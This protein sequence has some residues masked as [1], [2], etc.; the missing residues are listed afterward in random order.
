MSLVLMA[1]FG[2][3]VMYPGSYGGKFNSKSDL[4]AFAHTWRVFGYYAGI[5]VGGRVASCSSSMNNNL[6]VSQ[7]EYNIG[8]VDNTS[9]L[10]SLSRRSL[11]ARVCVRGP[12]WVPWWEIIVK[13]TCDTAVRWRTKPF[14]VL[15]RFR[16]DES[17]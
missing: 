14:F 2:S 15:G 3:Y 17:A 8:F 1:F 13:T 6:F 11:S 12:G 7:D 5:E 4:E 9:S 16:L 10:F